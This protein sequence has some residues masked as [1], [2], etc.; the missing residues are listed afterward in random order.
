M[1]IKQEL[2]NLP[3]RIAC[4]ENQLLEKQLASEDI[5]AWLK[6]WELEQIDQINNATDDSGK[7]LFSNDAKRRAELER[8]K[9]ASSE[10]QEKETEKAILDVSIK[11]IE[12]DLKKQYNIQANLR[13]ICRLMDAGEYEDCERAG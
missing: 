5:A 10:Y 3:S 7:P 12:I 9:Q 6:L 2:L 1:D 4:I 11:Q 8:R 13:A